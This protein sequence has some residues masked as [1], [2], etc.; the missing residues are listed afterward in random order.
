MRGEGGCQL[1]QEQVAASPAWL[2]LPPRPSAFRKELSPRAQ[3]L[4]SRPVCLWVTEAELSV[5]LGK[6]YVGKILLASR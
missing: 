1:V 3:C 2:C 5:L 4:V 6:Q